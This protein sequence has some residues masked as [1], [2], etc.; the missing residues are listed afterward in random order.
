MKA[1]VLQWCIIYMLISNVLLCT[2]HWKLQYK[3]VNN[4]GIN[5]EQISNLIYRSIWGWHLDSC[6]ICTIFNKTKASR[7]AEVSL[8]FPSN[9][10]SRIPVG[11]GQLQAIK[12]DLK[13]IDYSRVLPASWGKISRVFCRTL[14][15]L[16]WEKLMISLTTFIISAS[17]QVL[18]WPPTLGFKLC[19]LLSWNRYKCGISVAVGKEINSLLWLLF[20]A[21]FFANLSRHP[22]TVHIPLVMV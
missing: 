2:F 18:S 20:L 9:G 7:K 14:H 6:M 13:R 1:A 3:Y 5:E 10:I 11:L 15:S 21:G 12:E 22:S 8:W 19:L 4:D 17:L 16:G